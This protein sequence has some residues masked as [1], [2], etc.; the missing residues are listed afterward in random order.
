MTAAS[1]AAHG[2]LLRHAAT[3]DG[4]LALPVDPA[5]IARAE[6]VDMP[7]VQNAYGRWEAAVALGRALEP[8]GDGIGG[9]C[10]K[11][12]AEPGAELVPLKDIPDRPALPLP[13]TY[14]D[15]E[16]GDSSDQ[17]RVGDYG[18]AVRENA[19]GQDETPFHIER[20]GD[21]GLPV[22]LLDTRL[23]AKPE[24]D[25]DDGQYVSLLQLH[26]DGYILSRTGRKTDEDE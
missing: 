9:V 1:G 23:Y 12:A 14:E 17:P 7:P 4:Q 21:T 19:H 5:A 20:D 26:L 3:S 13:L 11:H 8:D 22:V 24:D 18:W 15:I 2:L 6:G 10:A 25:V 16:D